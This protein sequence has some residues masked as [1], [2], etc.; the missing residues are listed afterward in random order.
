MTSCNVIFCLNRIKFFCSL[1][2]EFLGPGLVWTYIPTEGRSRSNDRHK[3]ADLDTF[4]PALQRR[5]EVRSPTSDDDWS[6][7]KREG[8]PGPVLGVDLCH[9]A[10][11]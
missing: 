3:E 9:I 6:R 8:A 10:A 11:W 7:A 4:L 1:G 2:H 5:G